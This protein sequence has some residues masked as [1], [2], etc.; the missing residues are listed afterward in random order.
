[1][2][3][4]L[5]S[6]VHTAATQ[7]AAAPL[8][9]VSHL[10]KLYDIRH[11]MF[12]K[13]VGHVHAV[14]DVSFDIMSGETL[15]L[16]GESGSGKTTIGRSVLRLI[17]PTGG[18]IRFDG[19]DVMAMN[20][21][22]LREY[23]R[24]AQIIFQ[25]PFASI[26][27]RMKIRDVIAEPLRV[28]NIYAT[29]GEVNRRVSELLDLVSLSDDYKDRSPTALSGGQ[30]QRVV[31]ARALAVN[32]KFIVADEPISALDVS[33][34]AQ[35]VSLLDELKQ[36]LNLAMLFISHDLTVMEYL[37]DRIVVVYLGQIMEI[38]PARSITQTPKHPY[39][40]ALIS[41]V[42]NDRPEQRRKRVLLQGDVA[43]PVSPPSGCVF[44]TRCIYAVPE[45]AQ[46]RPAI[47][48]VAPLHF[49]ACI[50]DD[51]L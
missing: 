42:P 12:S 18:A 23:R 35:I 43:D 48:E 14:N 31:I 41:A 1:M 37:S 39:T 4:T 9:T 17:E 40:E 24:S 34:Q 38:G 50:R 6:P 32:P 30:R 36:R 10:R 11:G 49:K 7:A 22:A 5:D 21:S 20:A 45:C 8:L 13:L 46:Q 25:D 3:P 16:A 28:Q 47:R 44:R 19:R 29:E 33:I 15:G 2:T 27:P 26:N 51:V